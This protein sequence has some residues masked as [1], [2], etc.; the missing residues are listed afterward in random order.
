MASINNYDETAALY[1]EFD[2]TIGNP[3]PEWEITSNYHSLAG[4]Q[5]PAEPYVCLPYSN[6]PETPYGQEL[7]IR[8]ETGL[9]SD[10]IKEPQSPSHRRTP[11]I[12]QACDSCAHLRRRCDGLLTCTE[13]AKRRKQCTYNRPRKYPSRN[14]LKSNRS[15]IRI[16]AAKPRSIRGSSISSAV[17][18]APALPGSVASRSQS[19]RA[20]VISAEFFVPSTSQ[21]STSTSIQADDDEPMDPADK[22]S[23]ST[24]EN[25]GSPAPRTTALLELIREVKTANRLLGKV[26]RRLRP[27]S[28]S[29]ATQAGVT[30]GDDDG[31]ESR[32]T[33]ESSCESIPDQ[34]AG[35]MRDRSEPD[36]YRL[37]QNDDTRK[38]K[39][40]NILIFRNWGK[41]RHGGF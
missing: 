22:I 21:P 6:V 38:G 32:Q 4:Y 16:A 39:R 26:L 13:C 8:I 14:S 33:Q 15:S 5:F 36:L 27:H 37:P 24:D 12:R 3:Q 40:P 11:R 34:F 9:S 7:E 20:S 2:T 25:D 41:G 31:S 29:R 28:R 30:E 23:E 19:S 18:V 35:T 1:I 17:N 10:A